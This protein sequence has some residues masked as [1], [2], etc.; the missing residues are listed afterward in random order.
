M[1]HIPLI[2]IIV[3]C[4]VIAQLCLF[5]KVLSRIDN[6]KGI[7]PEKA[8][9]RVLFTQ[10]NANAIKS[11]SVEDI[12]SSP[13][14][15]QLGD[16]EIVF[17]DSDGKNDLLD[18]ILIS[19]NTYLLRNKGAA[20][21]FLLIKDIVERN[22][23]TED[24]QINA[25]LPIPLYLG[26]MG[27][28]LGIVVG[29][30]YLGVKGFD[31]LDASATE[32]MTCVG[33][34][35]IASCLGLLLT[36]LASGFVYRGAKAK[37]EGLKN[38]FYT[39]IQTELLP[40][41]SNNAANS[42]QTLQANLSKFNTGFTHN[43]NKFDDFLSQI[44]VSFE[45]QNT[46][47]SAL[48]DIDVAQIA[49]F[50][51]KVMKEFNKSASK[52]DEFSTYLLQVNDFVSNAV[53]L[54]TT[55]EKQLARTVLIED[56]ATAIQSNVESNKLLFEYVEKELEA[57]EGRKKY[58]ADTVSNVDATLK[59]S[60]D[61][62]GQST[63]GKL[64]SIIDFV[65]TE[66][67]SFKNFLKD[68]RGNL[69]ELKK[70]SP[71]SLSIEKLEKASEEQNAQLSKLNQTLSGKLDSLH[72]TVRDLSQVLQ[73]QTLSEIVMPDTKLTIPKMTKWLG[74]SF[75][76]LGNVVCIAAIVLLVLALMGK[77]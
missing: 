15:Y 51:L 73:K 41:V 71:M 11:L 46:L 18:N 36:T 56:I 58:L 34:A 17:I 13:S 7:F 6:F 30:G 63:K 57:I 49:S 65:N 24:E 16:T 22:C 48:K 23:D 28:M 68:D 55:L 12:L 76:I 44:L 60:L 9:L 32:L 72:G 1:M 69:D 4:I 29:V 10:I 66:E 74:Y 54:N 42:L 67:V 43:I 45:S 2:V 21:D 70:L 64:Q 3:L 59:K 5:Y 77:L 20:S 14:S 26:L 75:F 35:M 40:S 62:L 53:K 25:L 33:I 52:F 27:T 39:F 38:D 61:E 31:N 37:V 50:N 8:K 19:I 47:F